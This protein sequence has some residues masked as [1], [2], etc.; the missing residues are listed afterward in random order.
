MENDWKS[1]IGL[2]F[3]KNNVFRLKYLNNHLESSCNEYVSYLKEFER[4]NAHVTIERYSGKLHESFEGNVY[5]KLIMVD[6]R[7][8][9]PAF[10]EFKLSCFFN[11]NS[12]LI[13]KSAIDCDLLKNIEDSKAY[14][15]MEEEFT[16]P[17]TLEKTYIFG[18]FNSRLIQYIEVLKTKFS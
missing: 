9:N 7:A 8:I 4:V 1:D 3:A 16:E 15:Y 10:R 6:I 14:E 13:L 2:Y 11:A 12:H 17:E 5:G 18:L